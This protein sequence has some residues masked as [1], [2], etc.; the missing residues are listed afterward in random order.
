M[1][2]FRVISGNEFTKLYCDYIYNHM[3]GHKTANPF[4]ENLV[5]AQGDNVVDRNG[6]VIGKIVP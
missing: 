2:E 1:N 3:R 5:L 4:V 6:N